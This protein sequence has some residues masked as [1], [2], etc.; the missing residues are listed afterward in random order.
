M[1]LKPEFVGRILAL[2][3]LIAAPAEPPEWIHLAP[4][5]EWRGHPS[6]P[7]RIGL[8]EAQQLVRNFESR[9]GIRLVIDYEHQTL[10]A[11][12]SGQ[13][14]PAAGWIDRIELR[15]DGV[16]GHVEMWTINAAAM[17]RAREYRY[18]SPVLVFD[19]INKVSGVPE[20]MFIHSG[21]LTNTPFLDELTPVVMSDQ[22]HLENPM[23][24]IKKLLGLA[25]DATAE[26]V[27]S[28][29]T[30]MVALRDGLVVKVGT[31]ALAILKPAEGETSVALCER[32]VRE[33]RHSGYVPVAEHVAALTEGAARV[34]QL[35]DEQVLAQARTSGKLTPALEAWFSRQLGRDR[36]GAMAWLSDAPVVVP[37]TPA[38]RGPT[39]TAT[40]LTT[41]EAAVAR[42]LGLS[43]DQFL[44]TKKESPR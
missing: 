30:E 10:T 9:G 37:L 27:H 1:K 31:A 11:K 32:L 34:V 42:Q 7:F 20:G 26:Q 8:P 15:G 25:D 2:S 21:A 38:P 19:H 5:G 28:A 35:S 43:D 44:N 23:D 36:E 41:T 39:A 17:L 4:F 16:W 33:L 13:P 12:Y 40:T 24:E 14:A 29:I 6:G 3:A 18:F 22:P